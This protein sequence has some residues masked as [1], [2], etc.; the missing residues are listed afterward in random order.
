MRVVYAASCAE[1]VERQARQ[2]TVRAGVLRRFPRCRPR[3]LPRC[4]PRST[5]AGLLGRASRS[6]EF[7]AWAW[8]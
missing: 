3:R 6:S 7:L 8:P 1:R 2:R 4:R 5:L